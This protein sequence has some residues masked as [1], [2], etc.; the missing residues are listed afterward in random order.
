VLSD[1]CTSFVFYH[2][3]LLF[4]VSTS[5][6]YDKLFVINLLLDNWI[7]NQDAKVK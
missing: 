2:E 1:E 6:M 5:S 3:F 4:T 7:Q